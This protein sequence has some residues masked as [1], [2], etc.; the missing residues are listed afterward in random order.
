LA[1]AVIIGSIVLLAG[2]LVVRQVEVA[3]AWPELLVWVA[4]V[5][6]VDLLPVQSGE[7]PRLDMDLPVLLAAAFLFGP[8]PS[9]LVAFIGLFDPREIKRELSVT[10][11]LYNRSQKA[12]S[13]MAAAWV[14]LALNAEVGVWPGAMFAALLALAA[15]CT[16]N[17]GLIAAASTLLH[18]APSRAVLSRMKF[19]QSSVFVVAYGC[20]GLLGLILAEMYVRLGPWAL[21][22]FPIPVI[23]A[24]QAFSHGFGL[25][26]TK[27]SLRRMG[28]A[29]DQVSYRIA[30]ER[31]DER[32]RI[33]SSLHD[34]VLQSLYNVSI[35]AQVIREDLR[36]GRLLAL[37][38]DVPALL[39]ASEEAS[40][41]LRDV[42]QDLRRSP[43]GR[44]G[45]VDT[46]SLLFD[47]LQDESGMQIER[48]LQPVNASPLVQ[49]VTYQVAKEAVV[50]AVRHSGGSRV[51]VSLESS[52]RQL[53][54]T[55][56]DDGRGLG[57][58]SEEAH[59][60]PHFGMELM[61]ERVES[62]RGRLTVSSGE[63][64]G[65]RVVAELPTHDE[66]NPGSQRS[67]VQ[68]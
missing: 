68:G 10:C 58:P 20:L 61:R 26:A 53:R 2:G 65:L 48:D 43:L 27:A 12:L 16:T 62:V 28:L 66:L 4:L 36:A 52:D 22:S 11:A 51:G 29:F 13:V 21:I 9:G 14:F 31:K 42:I 3:A 63:T 59:A 19:G 55:V 44:R 39:R 8:T 67:G 35:H 64:A 18:R 24:R 15:D 45:L 47:Q 6:V 34:D 25:E 46:L 7:G 60:E 30:E 37:D 23:L 50:N 33:A 56:E 57:V 38:D 40:T 54:L 49:L 32:S 5:T 1:W 41:A 17:Y